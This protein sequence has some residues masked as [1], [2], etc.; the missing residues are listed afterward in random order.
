MPQLIVCGRIAWLLLFVYVAAWVGAYFRIKADEGSCSDED[1]SAAENDAARTEDE[2]NQAANT[3][4]NPV[5][6]GSTEA[7]KHP[8]QTCIPF[9]N[10]IAN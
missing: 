9:Y 3:E 5:S 7:G 1:G 4:D 10:A 2:E 8:N 6:M